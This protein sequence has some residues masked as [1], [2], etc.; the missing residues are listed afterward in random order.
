MASDQTRTDSQIVSP[1]RRLSHIIIE[2]VM[3]SV[4]GGRYPAK[5]IAGEPC[6][7]EAD[8]FRD[9]HQ[10]LRAAIKWRRKQ[11]EAFDEAPMAALDNDRWRGEFIPTEHA[12]YRSTVEGWTDLSAPSLGGFTRSLQAKMPIACSALSGGLLTPKET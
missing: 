3:P 12:R 11:D 4:D 7:V 5:R 2:D 8:I 10:V 1:A 6:V 9:G